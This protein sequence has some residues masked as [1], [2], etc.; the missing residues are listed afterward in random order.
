MLNSLHFLFRGTLRE[1]DLVDEEENHHAHAAVEDGGADVIQPSGD[2][3]PGHGNPDAVNRVHNAGNNAEGQQI[4]QRLVGHISLAAED[5]AALDEEIDDFADDHG[6][7]I[8]GEIGQAAVGRVIADDIPLKGLPEEGQVDARESKVHIGKE[9]EGCRQES[10]QQ[11]FEH[12]DHI[13][14]DHEQAALP[15]PLRRGGVLLREVFPDISHAL[16]PPTVS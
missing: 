15:H 7:H 8:G 9:R 2:K 14:D 13:A 6:D 12:R 5:E 16:L 4:P 3:H 1:D 11:I 10:Q